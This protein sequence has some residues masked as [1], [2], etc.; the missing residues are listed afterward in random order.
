MNIKAQKWIRAF[1]PRKLCVAL[2]K[3]LRVTDGAIYNWLIGRAKPTYER[4]VAMVALANE[5][6]EGRKLRLKV[7]DFRAPHETPL[8][9]EAPHV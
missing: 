7:D 6:K 9:E 3:D 8:P 1:G 5:T 4:S 2:P